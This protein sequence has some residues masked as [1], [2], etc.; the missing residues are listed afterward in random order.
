V[1]VDS[2]DDR[3]RLELPHRFNEAACAQTP[4]GRCSVSKG[5]VQCFDPR[6]GRARTE[7]PAAGS[8]VCT[9][10]WPRCS[11]LFMKRLAIVAV[12]LCA[13]AA[14]RRTLPSS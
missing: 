3:V 2:S 8:L 14:W 6:S 4:Q 12:A 9:S 7:R 13:S 5:K 11:A 1:R 10:A